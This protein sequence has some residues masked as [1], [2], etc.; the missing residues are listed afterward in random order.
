MNSLEG[1]ALLQLHKRSLG[2][3][4]DGWAQVL[5]TFPLFSGVSKRRLRKL[6]RAASFAEVARGE[7]V[8]A[9]GDSSDSLYVIL[10]GTA[11]AVRRPAARELGVGDYFGELALIDGAPRSATVVATSDLHVIRLPAHSARRLVEQHP[12]ITLTM[13]RNLSTQLRRQEAQVAQ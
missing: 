13:L 9:K 7:T 11:K 8:I 3:S 10:G 12:A 2:S 5:T 4:I 6:V 1:L